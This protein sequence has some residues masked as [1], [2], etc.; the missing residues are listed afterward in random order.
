MVFI[1]LHIFAMFMGVALS[2]GSELVLHR[3]AMTE[4]VTAIRTVFVSAQPIGRAIPMAYGIGFLLGIIAAL[5]V[6]FNLLA[7]WLLIS[8]VLFIVSS[9]LGGRVVGGWAEKVQ[10]I[11]TL[12][13]GDTPSAELVAVLHDKSAMQG[14]L[15]NL[16]V[17]A[18]IIAVMVF[19]PFGV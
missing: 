13:Q 7:P 1:Y 17:I 15:A 12:N 18:A 19:K 6:N 8:Y 4:N 16:I 5:V 10:R 2:V 9:I 14:M 11:A 3:V